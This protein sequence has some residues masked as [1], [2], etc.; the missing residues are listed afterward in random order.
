M[1]YIL[2][3]YMTEAMAEAVYDKLEDS[4]YSGHIPLCQGV[5]AFGKSLS[6]CE[7]ELRATLK[8]WILLGLRLGHALP[9]LARIDLNKEP[10]R[11]S[12]D[13]L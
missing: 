13:A 7:R 12:V 6:E 5:I 8:D 11:E 10:T 9:V 4:S 1:T 2:T 3:D